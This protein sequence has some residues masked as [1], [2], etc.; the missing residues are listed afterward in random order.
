LLTR[1]GRSNVYVAATIP[2]HHPS[3]Q[4]L[5]TGRLGSGTLVDASG[6][7]L[8]VN[9]VVLG[10]DTL[11]VTVQDGREFAAEVAAQDFTSG[12]AILR[13]T[14]GD[15]PCLSVGT[16]QHLRLGDEVFVVSSI[17]QGACRVANG[18]VTYLGPFD[19]N[20]EY[21]LDRAIMVS[22]L[23]PG[24]GGGALVDRFG[25]LV[26]VVSLGLSAVGKFSMVIPSE[27]F[28]DYQ[29]ELL[30]HGRRAAMPP[31]AWLG[32]FCYTMQD[33]VVVAGLLPGAPA[34]RAGLKQG[35]V[36]L[37]IDG[38]DVVDRRGLYLQLWTHRAG[39]AVRLKV[40]R[41]N[42]VRMIEVPTV[43]AEEFFA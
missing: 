38:Q 36:I 43:D 10:A 26:G 33:H 41:D 30:Q 20:W 13:V 4:L 2:E 1:A 29:G 27:Y 16:S 8:T 35:D 22:A 11:K 5:G 23:N 19:A 17:G 14:A 32:M 39:D 7:I 18:N 28:L 15:L 21:T 37:T 3:A 6:L 40:F 9:Y 12:L 34:E 31:R 25:N 42:E 24:L